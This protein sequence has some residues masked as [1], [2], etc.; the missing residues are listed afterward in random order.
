MV[1]IGPRNFPGSFVWFPAQSQIYKAVSAHVLKW[2]PSSNLP[3][4]CLASLFSYYDCFTGH[5]IGTSGLDSAL[6]RSGPC[7][8]FCFYFYFLGLVWPKV[9]I[10]IHKLI[11]HSW[12][13]VPCRNFHINC[14]GTRFL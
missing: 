14:F 1:E 5:L 8:S 10:A 2:I 11:Q 6:I 3:L 7:L 9:T 4:W 13:R 12:V